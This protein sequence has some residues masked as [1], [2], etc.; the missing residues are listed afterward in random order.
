MVVGL[1]KS[2]MYKREKTSIGA[3]SKN[4]SKINFYLN[5][6]MKKGLKNSMS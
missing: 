3:H 2:K 5:S 4:I 6:A 1:K